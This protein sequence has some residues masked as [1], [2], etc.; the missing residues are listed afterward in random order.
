M[1]DTRPDL[2]KSMSAGD[3]D[4]VLALGSRLTL[5]SGAVLFE[6]GIQTAAA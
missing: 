1:P 4:A 2:L 5:S 6:L 3:A